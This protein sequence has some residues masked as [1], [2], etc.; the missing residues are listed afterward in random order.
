MS[1]WIAGMLSWQPLNA[2][3]WA[4]CEDGVIGCGLNEDPPL[5]VNCH[6][7]SPARTIR[8]PGIWIICWMPLSCRD[9]GLPMIASVSMVGMRLSKFVYDAGCDMK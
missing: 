9:H 3:G 7:P 6:A 5:P 4:S 1:I 8:P 2:C